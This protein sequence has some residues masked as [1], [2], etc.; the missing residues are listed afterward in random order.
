MTT[1]T[2]TLDDALDRLAGYDYQDGVGF[3]CHGPMGAEALSSLGYDD[4]IP[5]W[6]ESYK[7]KHPPIAAPPAT[8]RI[9]PDDETSWR[10]AVGSFPRLTDWASLFTQELA[11]QPWPTVLRIWLPRLLPGAGGGLTHGLL[12]VAHGVRALPTNDGQPSELALN[13]LAR[14]LAAWAGWFRLLPGRPEL[15]GPL[16]LDKALDGLPWPAERWSPIEAG[17][18]TRL[19]ELDGF[20]AAVEALGP[21]EADPQAL[22]D[23][24]AA[25][26]RMLLASPRVF[27]QG[28]V[29]MVTPTAAVRTLLPYL[30]GVSVRAVYAQLWHVA[31]AIACGFLDPTSPVETP[32]PEDEPPTLPTPADL[33]ARAAE[34]GDPHAVKFTEACLRENDLRPDPVYLL[35]ARHVLDHTPAW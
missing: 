6:V 34:H 7:S 23:L 9:D 1:R 8:Q 21:P 11:E 35:A 13:E 32:P 22:S 20:T 16:T 28:P 17:M 31:A 27:P 15:R 14:G 25:F 33:A 5:R 10:A 30:P 4:L 19:D 18:F 12:R 24:T 26:C 2:D 3:A 29:H